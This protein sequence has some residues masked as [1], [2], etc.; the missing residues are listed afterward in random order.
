MNYEVS[1]GNP[2]S[3]CIANL[4]SQKVQPIAIHYCRDTL[5][6][7][8]LISWNHLIGSLYGIPI[9]HVSVYL[10]F[11]FPLL[12]LRVTFMLRALR[13]RFGFGWSRF[14]FRPLQC[15][16]KIYKTCKIVRYGSLWSSLPDTCQP[17]RLEL[18]LPNFSQMLRTLPSKW[19]YWRAPY[20][21]RRG[22]YKL[23]CTH[24]FVEGHPSIAPGCSFWGGS[25]KPLFRGR[26][27]ERWEWCW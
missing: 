5:A 6:R 26:V 4:M 22:W 15:T 9:Q 18:T 24:P 2:K 12:F 8:S 17:E 11:F 20:A 3:S 13:P 23:N 10:L 7:S 19:Y 21:I 16:I 27:K 14:V 1:G 25:S